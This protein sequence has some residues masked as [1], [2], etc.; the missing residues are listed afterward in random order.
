MDHWASSRPDGDGWRIFDKV[1]SVSSFRHPLLNNADWLAAAYATR[2]VAEM[3]DEIGVPAGS[4]VRAFKAHGIE[5]RKPTEHDVAM[6][7]ARLAD[8]TWLCEQHSKL[9]EQHSKVSVHDL[10]ARLGVCDHTVSK[11]FRAHGLAP[12]SK[13][14]AY[15]LKRPPELNDVDWLRRSYQTGSCRSIALELGVG[16]A[17]VRA[18]MTR[19]GVRGRSSTEVQAMRRPP[20]LDDPEA[21]ANVLSSTKVPELAAQL[22][23]AIS[24]VKEA[25]KRQGVQSPWKYDGPTRLTPPPAGELAEA[26][27]DAH[28]IKA[29]AQRF[30]VGVNTAAVWLARVGIFVSEVPAITRTDLMAAI[31]RRESLKVIG[32]RH[33][34]HSRTVIVELYRQGLFDDH[35]RRD[36]IDNAAARQPS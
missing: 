11:A 8:R 4:V 35:R 15:A 18:A 30:G 2:S 31:E 7:R 14:Q 9:C 6:R 12:P 28:T 32:R 26:W 22:G 36:V 20:L 33:H 25:M 23:V 5:L 19:L 16:D 1:C 27:N 24:T 13:A 3:A 21:L 17:M 34:V 10:A 29:V